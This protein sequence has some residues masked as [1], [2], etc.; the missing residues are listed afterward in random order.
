[1]GIFDHLLGRRTKKFA[2]GTEPVFISTSSSNSAA[3]KAPVEIQRP[4]R[5]LSPGEAFTP[6]QPKV[7]RRRLVGREAELGRILMALRE[8]HAHVVLYSERG[9]GKTSLANL[10]AESL[11]R[12]SSIVAR[13][14]CEAGTNFES[15]MRGLMHDL[16]PSLLAVR[17]TPEGNS[18]H[19][20]DADG[21]EAALPS[22]ELRPRDIVALTQRLNCRDLIF[23]IDE[24]D[25]VEDPG[26]RERLAD[27]IKQLSDQDISLQFFIVGVAENLDQILG[28]HP[29]IQRA[30]VGVHLSLFSDHDVALLIAR[31]GRE[32]GLTFRADVVTR[33]TVLARGMPYMAQL[34]GLRL[35]QVAIERGDTTVFMEDLLVAVERLIDEGNLRVLTLYA[36]LTDHGRNAEMVLA[37]RRVATAPQD[38]WGRLQVLDAPGSGVTIGGRSIT[39]QCWEQMQ[40]VHVLQSAMP[41]S[42]M[43]VFGERGLMHHVLL[44]AARDAAL[45]D[46]IP[47]QPGATPRTASRDAEMWGT[48]THSREAEPTRSHSAETLRSDVR[49]PTPRARLALISRS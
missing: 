2:A 38:P 26:T 17:S 47:A 33:L 21:C 37:L 42:G 31:G 28:E 46:A 11:R 49:A 44:L 4:T 36:S 9:R 8:D 3:P 29:S 41:G 10:V 39:A 15:L 43:F 18:R 13:H 6:T 27:T 19:D 40:A 32:S 1:M 14:T 45:M 30:V 34:L 12:A 22:G 5:T 7:G 24:F 35:S 20:V 16:P 23:V 48:G 25:R